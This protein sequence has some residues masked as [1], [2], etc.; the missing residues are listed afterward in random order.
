MAPRSVDDLGFGYRSK[1]LTPA[2]REQ[3]CEMANSRA[4][5][6]TDGRYFGGYDHKQARQVANAMRRYMARTLFGLRAS[7]RVFDAVDGAATLEVQLIER[8]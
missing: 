7:I 5:G 3:L 1:I 8:T 6:Q 4:F 2:Q